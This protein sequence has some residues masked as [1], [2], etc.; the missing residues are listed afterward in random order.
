MADR[1]TARRIHKT[2]TIVS[3]HSSSQELGKIIQV[4]RIN[5]AVIVTRI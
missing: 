5:R 1:R 2:V 3:F 4:I